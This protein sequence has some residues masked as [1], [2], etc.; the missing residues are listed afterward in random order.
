M[1]NLIIRKAAKEDHEGVKALCFRD[2]PN[3]FVPGI[4]PVWLTG[5]NTINL[6]AVVDGEIIG[7]FYGEIMTAQDAWVQGF[8][9]R[10]DFR[11]SG[12]GTKLAV[13][14]K[15]ELS[16]MGG[17]KIYANIGAANVA[18]LSTA[19]KLKWEIV[20]HFIRR[21]IEPSGGS[22][23]QT[24]RFS[25]EKVL[26]LIHDNPGLASCKKVAVFQRAYFSMNNDFIDQAI[27]KNAIRV[28]PNGRAYAIT[29]LETDPEEKI[30]VVGIAGEKTG[31]QW[32]LKSFID[33][34]GYRGVGLVI[35]STKNQM[36][37]SLMDQ[38]QFLPAGKDADY[39]VVRKDLSEHSF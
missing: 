22:Q 5:T 7:C 20:T 13:M 9:V 27:R 32:L 26:K 23:A 14:L 10:S 1:K 3:D 35:D 30:W 16:Q 39:V 11:K 12:V 36:I 17:E 21:E 38:F 2:N 33:D 15:N 34:A 19:S 24:V 18:S 4:W 6:V 37:Q 31:I 25:H 28:S 8:R 29:D